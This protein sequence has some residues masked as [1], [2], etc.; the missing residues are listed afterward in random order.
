MVPGYHIND[1]ISDLLVFSVHFMTNIGDAKL[2][3]NI[4]FMEGTDSVVDI[5]FTFKFLHMSL[6]ERMDKY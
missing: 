1:S 2:S 6:L 3:T 4:A 5:S